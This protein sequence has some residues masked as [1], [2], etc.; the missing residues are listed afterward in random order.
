MNNNIEK[1]IRQHRKDFDT[2]TPSEQVWHEIGKSIPVK[3]EARRF[4][5]RDMIKWS[6]A[7]AIVFAL[8]TSVY[9]LYIKKD[10][11]E[12]HPD[13][14]DMVN[15]GTVQPDELKGIDPE[16]LLQIK[17]VY[18]SV[19]TRQQELKQAAHDQPALYSQF[20]K[21][22]KVLDSSYRSLQE[23]A[24][25]TPNRDVLIKAMIQNLQL[26]GELL[27]RQLLI[28]NEIKNTQKEKNEKTI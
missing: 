27:N 26:Q 14:R 5:L 20:E 10:S 24:A 8:L 2:E 23:Q 28:I 13:D 18:Q 11:H 12:K 4:S 9:F 19:A 1:F 22:L 25:H 21:D 3:K 17:S 16:H 6:A 15:K 7:A